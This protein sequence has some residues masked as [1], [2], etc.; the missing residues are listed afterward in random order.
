MRGGSLGIP[1]EVTGKMAVSD[2][3]DDDD[4]D[5]RAATGKNPSPILWD[6]WAVGLALDVE[7]VPKIGN[8]HYDSLV[9][10]GGGH[11]VVNKDCPLIWSCLPAQTTGTCRVFFG[12]GFF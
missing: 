7:T 8:A 12:H 5:C 6:G 3:D 2:D 1:I 9:G 4:D 11:T 10:P